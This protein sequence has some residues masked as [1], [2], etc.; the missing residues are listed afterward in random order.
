MIIMAKAQKQQLIDEI[1]ETYAKID[2]LRQNE[3][4]ALYESGAITGGA[5]WYVYNPQRDYHNQ[6]FYGLHKKNTE[7][8]FGFYKRN[9]VTVWEFEY[10]LKLA[11][12]FLA[13]VE[14]VIKNGKC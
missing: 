7:S 1:F 9:R 14:E 11:K 3:L 5:Y 10:T 6:V 12:K 4:K 13:Q 2:E 8:M